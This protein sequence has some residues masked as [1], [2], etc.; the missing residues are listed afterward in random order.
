MAYCIFLKSFRILEEFRKIPTS[1]FHLD[2]LVQISKALANFLKSNLN[3]KEFF[4]GFW[5]NRPSQAVGLR[6]SCGQTSP[7]QG[8]TPFIHPEPAQRRHLLT[9][10]T[11]PRRADPPPT[12]MPW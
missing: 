5:P 2:L 11:T 7:P 3:S 1:K 9:C 4:L 12:S 6:S 8:V 10:V